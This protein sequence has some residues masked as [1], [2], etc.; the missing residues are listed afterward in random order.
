M[1][2]TDPA[3]EYAEIQHHQRL[4][5]QG[6]SDPQ[7]LG[8]LLDR[9][10]SAVLA[11]CQAQLPRQEAEEVVQEVF[12]TAITRIDQF[13]YAGS[14]RGWL[15]QI[16]RNKCRNARR[17]RRERLLEDDTLFLPEDPSPRPPRRLRQQER[18][19]LFYRALSQL[20]PDR[21]RAFQLFHL[22]GS[23][24]QDIEQALDLPPDGARTLLQSGRRQ[25][26]REILK[27]LDELGHSTSLLW[28][29]S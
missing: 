8:A 17:K 7:A 13:G 11:R 9:Y 5:A 23:S 18:A 10:R 2:G 3:Q 1:C 24:Y 28:T 4:K 15:L 20:P 21:R 19:E 14:L 22:D 25:L 29:R 6:L 16:A 12:L 26:R 27:L